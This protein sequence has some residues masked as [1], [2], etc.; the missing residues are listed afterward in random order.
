MLL[1]YTWHTEQ[2]FSNHPVHNGKLSDPAWEEGNK[3]N[4]WGMAN[5]NVIKTRIIPEFSRFEFQLSPAAQSQH[6]Q[7]QRFTESNR[8][9]YTSHFSLKIFKASW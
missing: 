8:K 9:R 7:Q 6:Y 5:S 3:Q 1:Q 2:W 4:W